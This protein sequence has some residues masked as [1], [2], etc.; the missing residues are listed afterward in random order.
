MEKSETQPAL[1]AEPSVKQPP[2]TRGESTS[3][4]LGHWVV[5]SL[6]TWHY[7]GSDGLPP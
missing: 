7:H 4:V 2:W 6:V 5:G 1:G 3:A